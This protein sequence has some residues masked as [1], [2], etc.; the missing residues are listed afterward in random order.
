VVVPTKAINVRKDSVAS[1]GSSIYKAA[2]QGGL[3]N[4]KRY[5]PDRKLKQHSKSKPF[6]Q[7]RQ[8]PLSLIFA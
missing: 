3:K 8:Q 1:T 2:Y 6:N 5:R 4:K 7:H